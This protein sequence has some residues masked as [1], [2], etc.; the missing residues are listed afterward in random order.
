MACV[1]YQCIYKFAD[2]PQQLNVLRS[3]AGF[4]MDGLVNFPTDIVW[5]GGGEKKT[6]FFY[7][8]F[9][10]WLLSARNLFS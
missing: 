4:W 3:A 1:F 6:F 2:N 8:P 5:K 9:G 10:T 7:F